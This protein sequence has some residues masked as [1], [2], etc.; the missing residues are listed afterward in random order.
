[1]SAID[2]GELL[3]D[4]LRFAFAGLLLL[5]LFQMARIMIREIDAGTRDQ[6]EQ[7]RPP[8]PLAWLIVVDGGASKL[9]AGSSLPVEGRVTIGRAGECDIAVDDGSVSSVHAAVFAE[10][11]QW[12]VEDFASMNGTWARGRPVEGR[13]PLQDGDL[14]Q[15]GR[16]QMRFLC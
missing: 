10:N 11:D 15:F 13:N 14:L 3:D 2:S 16:V 4:A 7:T 1:M 8:A 6:P 12:Y 9:V 5:F